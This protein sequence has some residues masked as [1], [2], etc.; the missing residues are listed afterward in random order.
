MKKSS[1]IILISR[2][3]IKACI[4]NSSHNHLAILNQCKHF[5]ANSF[6]YGNYAYHLT[7][8][9]TINYSKGLPCPLLRFTRCP[10][11][12]AVIHHVCHPP[13]C[14]P[15]KTSFSE[16]SITYKRTRQENSLCDHGAPG[17]SGSVVFREI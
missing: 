7:F 15:N 6:C 17:E 10:L 14:H 4:K 12:A 9:R 5:N 13:A 16:L 3:F 11:V 1:N 8:D 2:Y